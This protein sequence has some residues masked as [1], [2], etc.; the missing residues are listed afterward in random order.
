MNEEIDL[1]DHFGLVGMMTKKFVKL[2]SKQKMEETEEWSDGMLGL[3]KAKNA[4]DSKRGNKFS[5]LAYLHIKHEIFKGKIRRNN[6]LSM[7]LDFNSDFNEI[8]YKNK[9]IEKVD[10]NDLIKIIFNLIDDRTK[11]IFKMY[12][13]QGKTL[14]EIGSILGISKERVRKIKQSGIDDAR[15][16]CENIGI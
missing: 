6:N 8:I 10:E 14:A 4:F 1:Q 7:S 11:N 9:G 16:I 15:Q 5:T 2:Q 3:V 13:V 12:F